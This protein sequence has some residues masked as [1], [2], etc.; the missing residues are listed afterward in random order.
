MTDMPPMP[1]ATEAVTIEVDDPTDPES[2]ARAAYRAQASAMITEMMYGHS[3]IT[4]DD[5]GIHVAVGVESLPGTDTDTYGKA[6]IEAIR[7]QRGE[8]N[9]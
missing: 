3:A 7:E 6:P 9:E 2:Y 8:S 5:D 1:T 4:V